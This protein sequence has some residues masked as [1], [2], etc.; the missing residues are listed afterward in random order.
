[1]GISKNPNSVAILTE[2]KSDL[3]KNYS[4][5]ILHMRRR[6]FLLAPCLAYN[7]PLSCRLFVA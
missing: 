6:N 5:H 3:T 2:R 4:L 1:M 7:Q